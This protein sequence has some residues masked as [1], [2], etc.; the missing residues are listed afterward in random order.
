MSLIEVLAINFSVIALCMLLLWLLS[1]VLRD[2]SIVDLFWGTGFVVIAWISYFTVT[3]SPRS[4]LLLVLVTI[5]GMRLTGYLTWRNLGKP[6]DYRYQQMREH[7]G[8]RFWLLSLPIVFG[9]QGML[10]WIVSLPI[11]V[12]GFGTKPLS[13]WD[14]IGICLW[15]VGLFFE[16]V[17]DLQLAR[18]KSKPEN[19]GQVMDRG[20]WRYTR[21]PNYFG[22]FL[23]WWGF[24]FVALGSGQAW[25]T[26]ISPLVMSVLLIR[27]SGVA[28]LEKSLK[29]RTAGYREYVR[30]TSA[31]FPRPPAE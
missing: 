31:F 25:W 7:F 17:G 13:G 18:F 9:L 24:Y 26:V 14:A 29:N 2:V 5:W 27:V 8:K 3:P 4:T 16:A 6:E 11:Q 23:V 19:K 20:L 30:R 10:M 21:H 12:T 1:L 28:L 22:D 15:A